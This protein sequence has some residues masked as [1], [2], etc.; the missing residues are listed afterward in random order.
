[1]TT[2]HDEL[3]ETR[4]AIERIREQ[5]REA[6]AL[7]DELFGPEDQLPRASTRTCDSCGW[8]FARIEPTCENAAAHR[9]TW[10]QG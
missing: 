10:R 8:P 5:T 2:E 7:C 3:Q 4:D 9:Q 1:M 6:V